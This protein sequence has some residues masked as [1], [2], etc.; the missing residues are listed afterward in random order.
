MFYWSD[1][2][3]VVDLWTLSRVDCESIKFSVCMRSAIDYC[4]D[5]ENF[6][7]D[8]EYQDS[9]KEC[10]ADPEKYQIFKII[11]SK[12]YISIELKEKN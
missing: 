5:L 7:N 6:D 12:I 8:V 10:L 4:L 9:K 2:T 3:I 11:N 1:S